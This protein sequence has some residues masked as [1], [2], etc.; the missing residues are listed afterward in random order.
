[1]SRK[2]RRKNNKHGKKGRRGKMKTYSRKDRKGHQQGG[3]TPIN[4]TQR[5][6]GKQTFDEDDN[7]YYIKL[8]EGIVIDWY[9]EAFD[10]L[11]GG[12]TTDANEMRG[13]FVSHSDGK[14]LPYLDDP[15]VK[16][17]R[18]LR[19]ARKR[20]GI[21]LDD[22]FLET[23]KR[24]VLSE[25]NAWYCN[26]CKELRRATKTLEI[27]TIPDILVVH[28]KRFGGTRSFRDKIDVLVDYPI[29][30]L[31]M[32]ERIGL[33]E[34]GKEY[35]YDLFAVDNHYGGLGGGHYTALAK[36]FNDGQWYD[37]NG[38]HAHT[39]FVKNLN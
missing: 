1:M 18:E 19:E 27:W 28:L 38:K 16:A 34:D 2:G 32:T 23:G 7:P 39:N 36:N 35:V 31:N 37:Y 9:P 26:R 30:G 33:K 13:Q 8:G 25:D 15:E 20:H 5:F 14:G 6:G 12:S 24:E 11:F 10:G 22:C 3:F 29:E 21:T 17:K 4:Q